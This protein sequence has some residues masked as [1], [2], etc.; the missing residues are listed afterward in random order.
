MSTLPH[1]Q[2]FPHEADMGVRG[3]GETLA[4][5]FEQAG[6]ALT[7]VITD[8]D[9]VEPRE[10]VEIRCQ[11]PDP[12]ILLYDFL[13]SLVYEIAVGGRL[14]SRFEVEING[15]HLSARTW[16]EPV[17][18]GRHQPAVEVKGATFTQLRVQQQPDGHWIAQC[19]L[20][21]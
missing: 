15:E 10:P 16:G 3:H 13:N 18:V 17:D 1:W 8:L 9:G 20:D 7:A 5:A 2:H 21:I 12:E 6:L 19:V 14:F 11:A 4:A